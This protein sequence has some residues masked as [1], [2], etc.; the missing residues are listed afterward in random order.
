VPIAI[1]DPF[2]GISG[3]MTLGALIDRG[4]S[5]VWLTSI[6]KRL[7][8]DGVTATVTDGRRSGIACKKVDFTIPPQPYSENSRCVGRAAGR[9]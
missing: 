9:T 6:P 4:L 5:A 7:G 1:L 8:H 2:S 3:D